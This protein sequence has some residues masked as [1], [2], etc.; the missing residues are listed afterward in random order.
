MSQ[1]CNVSGAMFAPI[2]CIPGKTHKAHTPRF[3]LLYF[4]HIIN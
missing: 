4:K 2:H 1:L 3:I